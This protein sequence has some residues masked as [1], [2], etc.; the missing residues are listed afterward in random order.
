MLIA[1]HGWWWNVGGKPIMIAISVNCAWP[2]DIKV[3]LYF[4]PLKNT[5]MTTKV[6]LYPSLYPCTAASLGWYSEFVQPAPCTGN[7]GVLVY[8]GV[9]GCWNVWLK[10]GLLF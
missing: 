10:E 7:N 6:G 5:L 1:V 2:L 4:L 8:F 9:P 3:P